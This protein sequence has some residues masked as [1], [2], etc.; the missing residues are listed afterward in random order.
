MEVVFGA[1]AAHP[2]LLAAPVGSGVTPATEH[3]ETQGAL[4][5][6]GGTVVSLSLSTL[7]WSRHCS[8]EDAPLEGNSGELCDG[9]GCGWR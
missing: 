8:G 6:G 7:G 1:P 5:Q 4:G 9:A 3:Q 2:A